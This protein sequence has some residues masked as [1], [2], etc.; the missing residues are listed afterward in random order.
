MAVVGKSSGEGRSIV[1]GKLRHALSELKL[2]VEG[3]NLLPKLENFLFF[4][5]E[6]RFVRNYTK[7]KLLANDNFQK[8]QRRTIPELK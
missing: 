7:T 6:V 4:F 1:E 8:I 3:I 5:R 2:F